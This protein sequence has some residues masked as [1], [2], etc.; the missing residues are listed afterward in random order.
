[1]TLQPRPTAGPFTAATTGMRQRIMLSTS[2]RPSSMVS[3]R[4]AR[5]L[6]MRSSRSKSPPAENARPSPVITATRASASALSCGNSL[7]E[8]EVQ[9]VVD[10]VELLGARRAARC[11]PGRRP[12]RG[13]RRAGRTSS[14]AP[15]GSSTASGRRETED[16]GGD[17]VLLDLRRATHHALRAAVEVGLERDVV[18]VDHRA[19]SPTPRAPRSRPSVRPTS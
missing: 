14:S 11:G 1:M 2:S 12:R 13:S 17:D 15:F 5:S 10:R 18:G 6:A 19:A 4:S 3:R 8:A 7:R 16:P 9:L